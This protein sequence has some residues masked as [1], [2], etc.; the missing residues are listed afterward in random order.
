MFWA[1][2]A[3]SVLLELAVAGMVLRS[4]WATEVWSWGALEFDAAPM[5]G[6]PGWGPPKKD[7]D[8]PGLVYWGGRL[9]TVVARFSDAGGGRLVV[10]VG[11]RPIVAANKRVSPGLEESVGLRRRSEPPGPQAPGLGYPEPG[12]NVWLSSTEWNWNGLAVWSTHLNGDA[13]R[14]VRAPWWALAVLGLA[15][16]GAGGLWR[17]WRRWRRPGKGSCAACGYELKGLARCPECGAAG[18]R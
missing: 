8:P 12:G 16:A 5:A 18:A 11:T 9:R 6:P 7:P 17:A 2:V 13:G 15:P 4:R 3:A 1:S 14:Y 10:R